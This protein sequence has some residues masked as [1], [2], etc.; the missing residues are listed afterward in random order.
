MHFIRHMYFGCFFFLSEI[1]F[2]DISE[3][4][5]QCKNSEETT[6]CVDIIDCSSVNRQAFHVTCVDRFTKDQFMHIQIYRHFKP[7]HYKN[8]F[9]SY[10]TRQSLEMGRPFKPRPEKP[11]PRFISFVP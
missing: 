7:H 6:L 5:I 4:P 10:I 8:E 2:T 3:I 1:I 11:S 9:R